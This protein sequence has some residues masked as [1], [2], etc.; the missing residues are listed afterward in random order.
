ALA[1]GH[2]DLHHAVRVGAPGRKAEDCGY[3][4][5]GGEIRPAYERGPDAGVYALV[6]PAA[7]AELE[8][9]AAACGFFYPRCFCRDEYLVV[10]LVE[11]GRFEYL[12][13]G[14][15]A[16]DYRN[17][18]VRVDHPA[19]RNRLERNALEAAVLIE[20]REEVAAEH[21]GAGASLP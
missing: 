18:D 3:A 9:R 12:R 15:G 10:E 4:D 8:Y 16:L 13:H 19:L 21:R 7:H 11:K 17:R 5:A 14:E 2:K 1:E 6:V 20:P